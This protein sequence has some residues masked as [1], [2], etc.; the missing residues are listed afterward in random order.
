MIVEETI[1]ENNEIRVFVEKEDNTPSKS[2]HTCACGRTVCCGKHK[3]CCRQ[4]TK[5]RFIDGGK[6]R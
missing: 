5:I 4:E 1:V 3:N 2:E 6:T